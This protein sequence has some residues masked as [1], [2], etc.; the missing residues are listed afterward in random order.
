MQNEKKYIR[1]KGITRLPSEHDSFDGELED[2][3]NMALT[4]GELRPV[5]PPQVVGS[6]AGHFL[7]V[8]KNQGFEHFIHIDGSLVKASKYQDG[9]ITSLGTITNIGTSTIKTINA[10]GNTL[11]IL[12]NKDILYLLWKDGSY[13]SLGTQIPFPLLKFNLTPYSVPVIRK[14]YDKYAEDLERVTEVSGSYIRGR[15][16]IPLSG[17]SG[18]STGVYRRPNT[19]GEGDPGEDNDRSILIGRTY[20]DRE[21]IVS[22]ELENEIFGVINEKIAEIHG[23]NALLFPFFVRYAIRMY[24]GSLVRHSQPFL[25]LPSKFIPFQVG[26]ADAEENVVS[27][28]FTPSKL[29]FTSSMIESLQPFA[30]IVT[31]VDI[32]I[33]NPIYSYLPDGQIN[34]TVANPLSSNPPK[35][36]AGMIKSKEAILEEIESTGE[37]FLLHSIPINENST[38]ETN[39]PLEV[40]GI[41]NISSK[42]LM[43]DDYLTHNKVLA[44]HSYT[45]N[46]KLHLS[47]VKQ[48]PFSGFKYTLD[49]DICYDIRDY[50]IVKADAAHYVGPQPFIFYPD[51]R[52]ASLIYY[53][54]TT[55][56]ATGVMAIRQPLS[57]HKRLN[58]AFYLDPDLNNVQLS[59][60]DAT[61]S[62]NTEYQNLDSMLF[63]SGFQNPFVFPVN[64]R[65]TLP[66]GK[67]LSVASN[68]QAISQ[69][70]FGQFPLYAFTDDGIW[71][72]EV[73]SDGRYTARQPVSRDV[74]INPNVLQMDSMIAFITAKGVTLLSGSDSQPISEIIRENNIRSSQITISSMLDA[75]NAS[76]V[77]DSTIKNRLQTTYNTDVPF[78][79]FSAGAS[80][81]Y[82]YIT[83]SGRIL[84]INPLYDYSYVFDLGTSTW[85]KVITSYK[86]VVN[87]YPDCYVQDG[88]GV[89]YNLSHIPDA[90]DNTTTCMIITRPIKYNDLNFVIRSLSHRGIFK[91]VLNV[92]IYASRNG[93]DYH[94]IKTGKEKLI[95]M[96]GS[97][98]MY[99]KIL[100]IANLKPNEVISGID[101]DFM[102]KYSNRM[103]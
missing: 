21:S 63:V 8:H 76:G 20:F 60:A 34:G 47:G 40:K 72:L 4:G 18:R 69:G 30:D 57:A 26:V 14:T 73:G 102:V 42:E 97:G 48:Q 79:V 52:A 86:R 28:Y 94:L 39:I 78:E 66:V 91:S 3:V 16:G 100:V 58:G 11:I 68:T 1:Y 95:R 29:S 22:S 75:L 71:A 24:D 103:R 62:P 88:E 7:F 99:Y 35:I 54:N 59:T 19:D 38:S 23:S 64:S 98:Y 83:G 45:Y 10:I 84:L 15:R 56:G 32:F 67:V 51:P 92:G 70:Q 44:E 85:S 17:S 9:S 82:D 2:V 49:G 65:L 74:A 61:D 101:L 5:L 93:Q 41:D 80:L 43:S 81:A 25:M 36:F 87:N 12:T 31:S 37:F 6:L 33:S 89:V 27:F 53:H 77:L 50:G 13:K 90:L 46:H 55:H 96:T